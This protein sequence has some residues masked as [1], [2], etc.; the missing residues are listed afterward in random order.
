MQDGRQPVEDWQQNI[1]DGHQPMEDDG[2][3]IIEVRQPG[4]S[5]AIPQGKLLQLAKAC[6]SFRNKRRQS[7]HKAHEPDTRDIWH[8]K[9]NGILSG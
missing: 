4:N 7:T 3:Q 6:K 5:H 9:H 8:S 2:Q 1:E